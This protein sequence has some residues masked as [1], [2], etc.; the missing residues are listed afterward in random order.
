VESLNEIATLFYGQLT[1]FKTR[2]RKDALFCVTVFSF[3]ELNTTK[4]VIYFY[5]RCF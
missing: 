5:V 1:L 2:P 3:I 4:N